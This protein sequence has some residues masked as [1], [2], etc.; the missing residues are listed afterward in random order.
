MAADSA[1]RILLIPRNIPALVVHF[2]VME[3]GARQLALPI[4]YRLL[5]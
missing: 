5:V 2:L 1:K 3:N 4:T